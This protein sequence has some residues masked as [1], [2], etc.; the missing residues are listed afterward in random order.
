MKKRGPI[1]IIAGAVMIVSAMMLAYSVVQSASPGLGGEG[2]FPSPE[3]MFDEVSE[4]ETIDP[5]TAYTFSHT[6]TSSQVPLMWGLYITD[7]KPDDQVLVT[8]SNI[9]GDKFGSYQEGDPIFIKSFMIPKVDTYNFYVENKGSES[10]TVKIMY[11]ENPEKSKALTDPNSP[12]YKNIVPLATSGFLLIIGIA[13]IISGIILSVIDWKR[14][15]N[16]SRYI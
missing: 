2:F 6:T 9:F 3:S 15:K 13:V 14:G 7:Y 10:I 5:G 8:V 1:V 12:F 4:K 16:Q 11:S